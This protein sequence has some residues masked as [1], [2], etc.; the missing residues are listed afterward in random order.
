MNN[1]NHPSYPETSYIICSIQIMV[2][3]VLRKIY[4][5]RLRSGEVCNDIV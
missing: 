3:G 1:D 2:L 5:L 4:N